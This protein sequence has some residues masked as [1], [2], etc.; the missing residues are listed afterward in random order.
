MIALLASVALAAMDPSVEQDL[1]CIGVFAIAASR[2]E[3]MS[4]GEQAGITGAMMFYLG[5]IEGHEPEFHLQDSLTELLQ[6]PSYLKGL[7]E[8]AKRCGA[9]MMAK[10]KELTDLGNAMQQAGREEVPGGK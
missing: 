3:E 7:P 5:R 9:E 4:A 10:G 2:N 1:R 6:S 8:E